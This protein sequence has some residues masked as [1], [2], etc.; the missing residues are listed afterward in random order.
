MKKL[1]LI[2]SVLISS[3]SFSQNNYQIDSDYALLRASAQS[4]WHI[5]MN[6]SEIMIKNI[7]GTIEKNS[8]MQLRED[9]RE[10][11]KILIPLFDENRFI[12][13]YEAKKRYTKASRFYRKALKKYKR[14]KNK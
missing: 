11:A 10:S 1:L 8:D 3:Y 7:A 13:T 5:Y 14:R 9:L 2:I 6:N 12:S 4:E